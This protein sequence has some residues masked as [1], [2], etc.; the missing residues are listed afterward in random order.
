M[1]SN[2][3]KYTDYKPNAGVSTV[4]FG[5]NKPV[6]ESE[7]NELQEITKHSFERII[8]AFIED[9]MSKEGKITYSKGVL[10][11]SPCTVSCK[12]IIIKNTGLSVP[13]N[14]GQTAY[15]KVSEIDAN[16]N[17]EIKEEGNKQSTNT[18]IN[19]FKDSR[20]GIETTKRKL[21]VYDL[22]T[23]N[24]DDCI[25]VARITDNGELVT[26]I[27][28]INSI[29]DISNKMG[30]LNSSKELYVDRENGNDVTGDGTLQNPYA[31]L[32]KAI[33]FFPNGV[34]RT[35]RFNSVV[36]YDEELSIDNKSIVFIPIDSS[37]PQLQVSGISILNQSSVEVGKLITGDVNISNGSQL[38]VPNLEANG[39]T[40]TTNSCVVSTTIKSTKSIFASNSSKIT[41]E[42]LTINSQS[43]E[44]I[45]SLLR[46]YC[47]SDIVC[48]DA[49]ISSTGTVT[50]TFAVV[51]EYGSK[52]SVLN[53]LNITKADK[54]INANAS[55]ITYGS[56]KFS[57]VP[58]GQKF[59]TYNGG[60]IFTAEDSTYR[61][62]AMSFVG[63]TACGVASELVGVISK[64]PDGGK[65]ELFIN[66]GDVA[67]FT[68]LWN[69]NNDTITLNEGS[70]S[71]LEVIGVSQIAGV[72]S[73]KLRLSGFAS[74]IT[75]EATLVDGV[76]TPWEEVA[77]KSDSFVV[78]EI[79]K[80][81]TDSTAHADKFT[82]YL[83]LTG[84]NIT[85]ALSLNDKFVA[86]SVNGKKAD[87]EGNID[88]S[89]SEGTQLYTSAGSD[90]WTVPDG[91][92][93]VLVTA[94][95][96][97]GGG[98][99]GCRTSSRDGYFEYGGYGGRGANCYKYE[100]AVTAGEEISIVIGNGGGPASA[101]GATSFGDKL[102]L[103]GGG[104][105]GNSS[106]EGHLGASAGAS[107]PQSAFTSCP[108]SA[109]G[110][111]GNRG[112]SGGA[113]DISPGAG[114]RGMMLL[115]WSWL[116]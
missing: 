72:S 61:A 27:N 60:R 50:P 34:K 5:K 57:D 38:F 29:A 62:K 3:D 95:A 89:G 100:I 53:V 68:E 99:Y 92:S 49:T 10:T 43:T 111:G 91:I 2:F 114:T 42:D 70:Y 73:A 55:T 106:G 112:G 46:S 36:S 21:V 11:I 54:G 103:S 71:F 90:T 9:G 24:S 32:T 25:P 39:V 17:S 77:Y 85:G 96:G 82:Q 51:S 48:S 98:G 104:A 86:V 14:N 88:M 64:I 16:Y 37:N 12:G 67:K 18:I 80:H 6:L 102:T 52:V 83:P 101:G 26:L 69:S 22:V 40:V 115:E 113:T 107:S 28:V 47:N 59:F 8:N 87:A 56:I 116:S 23:E 108:Y 15:L 65:Q 4:V 93:K 84:G 66:V 97:G 75:R 81:N 31:T 63:Y 94:S 58:T 110:A 45:Y 76:Y 35:I 44:N 20:Y 19:Y 1:S 79:Q 7:M 78:G 109:Y 33:G 30:E 105:G 74:N 41:C 13:L